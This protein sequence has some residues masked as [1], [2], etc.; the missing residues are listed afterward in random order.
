MIDATHLKAHRI[1]CQRLRATETRPGAIPA[2]LLEGG[3][4]PVAALN[5]FTRIFHTRRLEKH[6]WAAYVASLE[7]HKG[8][9]TCHRGLF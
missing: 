7:T 3:P 9:T 8:E 5:L 6:R 4:S 1:G 2:F